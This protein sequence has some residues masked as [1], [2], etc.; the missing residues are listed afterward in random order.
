MSGI[1]DIV[2]KIFKSKT[3][4]VNWAALVAATL[5]VWTQ[6]DLIAQ[7]PDVLG[8]MISALAGVNLVMRWLT[9]L[10]LSDK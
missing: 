10:P 4:I 5:T 2:G 8:Y 9:T 3:L 6:S 1:W 7:H